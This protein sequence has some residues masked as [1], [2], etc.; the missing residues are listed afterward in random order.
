MLSQDPMK[1][2]LSS[3]RKGVRNAFTLIELLVVIAIIAILAAMLLPALAK[4]KVTANRSNCKSNEKQ[5]LLALNIY[6]GDNKDALPTSGGNWAHDMASNAVAGMLSSGTTYKVWYDPRD[7][8]LGTQNI[9]QEW[10]NWITSGYNE[11]GY[12]MT[13]PGTASYG[14]DGGWLFET[15][16][17]WK[18]SVTYVSVPGTSI[19]FTIQRSGRPQVACEMCTSSAAFGI[20]AAM[21]AYPWNGLIDNMYTFTSAHMKSS[22]I[23]AGVNIGMIDGHVEWR[24]FTSRLVLPRAGNGSAPTYY[25]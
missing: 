5:Q 2:N 23:P 20:G 18:E 10:T 17:N 1:Q 3:S 7:T 6:A 15:N 19:S 12:A 16:L 8:G 25:Y 22:S 14:S 24:S 11:I 13:F 4:A 21:N 9:Q